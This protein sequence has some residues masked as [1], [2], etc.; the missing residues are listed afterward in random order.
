MNSIK[1]LSN[2][3]FVKLQFACNSNWEDCLIVDKRSNKSDIAEFFTDFRA[4]FIGTEAFFHNVNGSCAFIGFRLPA[5]KENIE[6]CCR[7]AQIF[8]DFSGDFLLNNLIANGKSFFDNKALFE[9][10]PSFMELGVVN[11]WNSFGPMRFWNNGDGDQYEC[12]SSAIR[13]E[14]RFHGVLPGYPAIESAYS[15][16]LPSWFGFPAGVIINGQHF[17]SLCSVRDFFAEN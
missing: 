5:S 1:Q 4:D 13:K 17:L 12:F 2:T 14:T 3:P 16:P 11:H 6:C 7:L 10:A 9:R 15:T 8:I